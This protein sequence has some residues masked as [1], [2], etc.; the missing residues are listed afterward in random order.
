MTTTAPDSAPARADRATLFTDS[1]SLS[2]EYWGVPSLGGL[3]TWR[4]RASPLPTVSRHN[5]KATL[6]CSRLESREEES[7]QRTAPWACLKNTATRASST[8]VVQ[9]VLQPAF[10]ALIVELPSAGNKKKQ[11]VPERNTFRTQGC[12]PSPAAQTN[13]SVI[14]AHPACVLL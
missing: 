3:D 11:V 12:K 13:R 4:C 7:I 8:C 14:V 1:S 6:S 5:T 9:I 2:R 10:G